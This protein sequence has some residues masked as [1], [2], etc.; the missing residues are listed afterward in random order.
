[1]LRLRLGVFGHFMGT[2]NGPY[3]LCWAQTCPLG[4]EAPARGSNPSHVRHELVPQHMLSLWFYCQK[5]TGSRDCPSFQDFLSVLYC[6]LHKPMKNLAKISP[7]AQSH[8]SVC[9]TT[10]TGGHSVSCMFASFCYLHFNQLSPSFPS[11]HL[12]VFFLLPMVTPRLFC[13]HVHILISHN[14]S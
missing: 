11:Q 14:I 9:L 12:F 1:M 13:K 10:Q 6:V 3:R 7:Q 5:D 8:P 2:F 4:G